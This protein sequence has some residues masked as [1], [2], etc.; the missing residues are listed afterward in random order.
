MDDLAAD[1]HA[2]SGF[3]NG[4]LN[5]FG[6]FLGGLGAALGKVAHF[7]GNDGKPHSGFTRA[8][9]LN[10]RVQGEDIGLESNLIN[11]LDDLGDVVAGDFDGFHGC[12]H[13]LHVASA[14][15][16]GCAGLLGESRWLS[17]HSRNC[18]WSWKP[19][20]PK[21]NWFLPA[22]RPVRWR[23][24]QGFG[25]RRKPGRRHWPLVQSRR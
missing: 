12:G 2:L 9:G 11:G 20:L 21:K 24:R 4:A 25:W 14:L 22:T 23:P 7:I 18:V 10:R 6:G 15:V 1:F 19:F 8:G 17:G 5:F 3:R 13:G 16:G